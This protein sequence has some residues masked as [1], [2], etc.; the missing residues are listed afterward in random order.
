MGRKHAW[1]GREYHPNTFGNY[2]SNWNFLPRMAYFYSNSWKSLSADLTCS[3]HQVLDISVFIVL[4]II[5]FVNAR[6]SKYPKG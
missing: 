3:W 5:I 2:F 1:N 6:S 4:I